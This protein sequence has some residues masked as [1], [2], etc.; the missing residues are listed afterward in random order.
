[1]RN[2]PF[3][4]L[5]F[6]LGVSLGCGPTKSDRPIVDQLSDP[7]AYTHL[8]IPPSLSPGQ[9]YLLEAEVT[10]T[11]GIGPAPGGPQWTVREAN[12]GTIAPEAN[13]PCD[14]VFRICAKYTAPM[15]QGTYHVDVQEKNFPLVK[16]SFTLSVTP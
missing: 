14:N 2:C 11:G 16:A 15:T 1:M 3:L 13:Y 8:S 4:V 12:G 10:R 6:V 7:T 5:T 9:T